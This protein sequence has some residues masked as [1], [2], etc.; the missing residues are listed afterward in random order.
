[1]IYEKE[2]HNLNTREIRWKMKVCL[3][4]ACMARA[5]LQSGLTCFS[6]DRSPENISTGSHVSL[7]A[8]KV[9]T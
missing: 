8:H 2:E 6:A 7:Y 3:K 9:L 5:R 4:K 1:M